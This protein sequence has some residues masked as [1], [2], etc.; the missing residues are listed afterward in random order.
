MRAATGRCALPMY[1]GEV[2]AGRVVVRRHAGTVEP[3]GC[4]SA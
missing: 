2:V 4:R 3:E 1:L